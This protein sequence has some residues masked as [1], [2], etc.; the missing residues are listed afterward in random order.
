MQEQDAGVNDQPASASD[1]IVIAQ[2]TRRLD[3]F[4][5][6]LSDAEFEALDEQLS[7]EECEEDAQAVNAPVAGTM[8]T[9]SI[10][11]RKGFGS[12]EC[13]ARDC[14]CKCSWFGRPKCKCT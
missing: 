1:P 3:E 4:A 13:F 9:C 6:T 7:K 5:K 12:G 14:K 8:G 11:C 2:L 10:N